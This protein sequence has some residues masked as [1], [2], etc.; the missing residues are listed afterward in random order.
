MN[1]LD[2]IPS[3]MLILNFIWGIWNY[4]LSKVNKITVEIIYPSLKIIF[5]DYYYTIEQNLFKKISTQNRDYL[6]STLS[7]LQ[8]TIKN[9]HL[10]LYLDIW[11]LINLDKVIKDL[12]QQKIT[13]K[14]QISYYK[15]STSYLRQRNS[16][17]KAF[18]ITRN[19]LDYRWH[20]HLYYNKIIFII[21]YFLKISALLLLIIYYIIVFSLAIYQLFYL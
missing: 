11:L 5:T 6:L 20:F 2:N 13:F 15:F 9:N 8:H 16:I 1:F 7:N 12:S 21:E 3:I 18:G 14:T 4:R 17:R 10:H 19:N